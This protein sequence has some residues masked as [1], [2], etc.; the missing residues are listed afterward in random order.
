[1]RNVGLKNIKI[2]LIGKAS[3]LETIPKIKS[4][5]EEIR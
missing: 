2:V 5:G 4:S 1:M 3:S